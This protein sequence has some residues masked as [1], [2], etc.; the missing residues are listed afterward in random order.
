MTEAKAS[1]SRPPLVSINSRP[2]F[3]SP[4]RPTGSHLTVAWQSG[5]GS[6]LTVV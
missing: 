3:G 6:H 5:L 2:S 1:G 4:A